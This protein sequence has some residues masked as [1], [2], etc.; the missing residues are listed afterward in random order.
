VGASAI[1]GGDDTINGGAGNDTI[2]GMLGSDTV[3]GNGG[4]DIIVS[5][6]NGSFYGDG[7]NDTIY[8]VSGLPE[9]LDGGAGIDLLDT[10]HWTGTYVIDLGTGLTNYAGESF[11]NFE[12]LRAGSGSDT[13]T[14]TGVANT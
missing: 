8:A 12:N 10:T 11:V 4:D 3:H 1:V 6:G 13:L 7:G 14:G 9:M 5:T 2:Y